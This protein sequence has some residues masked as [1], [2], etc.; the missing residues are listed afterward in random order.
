[1]DSSEIVLASI[2]DSRLQILK[3]NL[4]PTI[5]LMHKQLLQ[6]FIQDLKRKH[7]DVLFNPSVDGGTLFIHGIPVHTSSDVT[8]FYVEVLTNAT[9]Q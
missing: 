9:P 3:A 2:Q 7:P 1:M 8:R 6:D 5:I 4:K